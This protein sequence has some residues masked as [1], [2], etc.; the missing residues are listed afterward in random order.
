MD[1]TLDSRTSIP[2]AGDAPRNLL[3][4]AAT[5]HRGT[6][7]DGATLDPEALRVRDLD[8]NAL[9]GAT[10]F[11]GA[12]AH[13]WFDVAP[14]SAA[15]RAHEATLGARLAAFADALAPGS[16]GQSVA[17]DLGAAGVAPVFA[18][19]SGLLRGLDD[20]TG[21][22]R[23]P[24]PD[25]ADLDTMLLCAAA[26]PF[27]LHAAIEG[28]PFAA[29]TAGRVSLDAAATQA[30]RMLVLTGATRGDA[31]AQAAM[32]ML[33]VAWHAGFGYITP[34]VLAPRVA[35]GTG[36]TLAQ[37]IASGFLASGPS[38]VGAALEA[39]QWL[40]ALARSVPG[41]A[42]APPAALDAAGRGAIDAA[43][44]AKRTLYGFGHPLFVADPRPPHLRGR[45][46]ACGFDGGYVTLFD[47]C[48]AQAD[49]RRALRPNIDFLTAATLLELGVAAPS[50]GVGVGLGARIAAMAAHAVERRRRPAFGVNSATA[51][52]LL[53]AVPV[54]WL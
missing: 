31:P 19:A 34:T 45:F 39:M 17:A 21:R 41:G 11:E 8:L 38:H 2:A 52:R 3:G 46:A 10:T 5:R 53:A 24:A 16:V 28:R 49:A 27:L 44:D 50:W 4:R 32:D 7:I 20:V 1:T 35:I 29:G 47:A 6:D 43:L 15:H 48:C 9:I 14:G 13:L 30:Q 23:G 33:L 54:G 26:A 36:V 12:L 25:D 18:A 51:R 37:A 40:A 22:V 42:G